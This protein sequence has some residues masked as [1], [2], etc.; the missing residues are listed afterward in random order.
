MRNSAQQIFQRVREE[1]YRGGVTIVRDYVRASG[2]QSSPSISSCILPRGE[3]ARIDWGSWGTV[4]VGNTP[5]R[6]FFFV[7]VLAYSR[8]NSSVS[9]A[10]APRRVRLFHPRYCDFARHHGFTITPCSVARANEKG[11]VE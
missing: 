8:Q 3:C 10:A 7:M 4:A 11:R 2:P 5:R 9:G 1:G 6:L